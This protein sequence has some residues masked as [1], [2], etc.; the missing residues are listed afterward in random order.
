MNTSIKFNDKVTIHYAINMMAQELHIGEDYLGNLHYADN[1]KSA[2]QAANFF[3]EG[4]GW[5]YDFMEAE[6]VRG[7]QLTKEEFKKEYRAYRQYVSQ[8]K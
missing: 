7:R 1:P 5:D 8:F 6:V 4:W 3:T 2:F